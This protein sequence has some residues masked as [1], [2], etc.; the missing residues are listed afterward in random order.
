MRRADRLFRIVQYLRKRKVVTARRLADEL[1]VSE[2]TIYR[3]VQ[4]LVASGVPIVGEAGVGY[5]L[6]RRFDLP[7][8]AFDAGELA[9]LALGARM[10]ESWG[11][12]AL[13]RDARSA[14]DKIE[15]ILPER[16]RP[17][18]SRAPLFAPGFHV[19]AAITAHVGSLRGAVDQA[20]KVA[21]RY[22]DRQKDQSRRVVRP[23]GLAFWGSTWS[24]AAWCELR[25]DFRVFRLDRIE[26]LEVLDDRFVDEPERSIEAFLRKM[27]EE[28]KR[29]S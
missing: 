15:Q 5:A 20:R 23:L 14:I 3:D 7:P 13:A 4:D 12:A 11:D 10:V 1:E 9:A 2:R 25:E 19:P 24:L 6:D 27:K 22:V 29:A 21:L 17:R 28:E 16:L 18:L 8:I 26:Q